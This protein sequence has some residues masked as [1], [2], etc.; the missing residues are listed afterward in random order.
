[1]THYY[2]FLSQIKIELDPIWVTSGKLLTLFWLLLVLVQHVLMVLVQHHQ[3]HYPQMHLEFDLFSEPV[4]EP[5]ILQAAVT[6]WFYSV[7]L[8]MFM[9]FCIFTKKKLS[10]LT[11]KKYLEYFLVKKMEPR[12]EYSRDSYLLHSL[13]L[14][15]AHAISMNCSFQGHDHKNLSLHLTK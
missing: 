10:L 2:L 7:F 12:F 4:I 15:N 8:W 5:S 6:F 3:V 13:S 11:P 9:V 1:M 14:Y